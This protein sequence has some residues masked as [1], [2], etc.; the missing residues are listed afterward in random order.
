MWGGGE[1]VKTEDAGEVRTGG[2]GAQNTVR[3]YGQ[4]ARLATVRGW[5][6]PAEAL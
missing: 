4:Y 2:H 3:V 6:V 1:R 5:T